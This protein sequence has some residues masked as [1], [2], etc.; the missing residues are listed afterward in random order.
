ML[1]DIVLNFLLAGRDTT[2]SALSW[3]IWELLRNPGA[4]DTAR[5]SF[6]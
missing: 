3:T 2:A 6:F 5:F 1:V 4:L